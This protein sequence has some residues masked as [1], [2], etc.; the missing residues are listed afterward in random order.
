MGTALNITDEAVRQQLIKLAKEGLVEGIA[1]ANGVGR[2]V[3]IWQL[4]PAGNAR[5]PDAH[6]DLTAQLLRSIRTELGEA[7]LERLIAVR[8]QDTRRAYAQELAGA[9]DLRERVARLAAIRS[10][11]GYMAGWTEEDDG[12]LLVENHCPICVAAATCQGF[13]RAEL[14]I[15]QEV[16]G[17]E[18]NVTRIEYILSSDRRCAYR[19]TQRA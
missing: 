15:F 9:T 16:L 10:R 1:E 12:Y 19:I 11:E 8:E 4:T 18:A 13:C 7:A 5:F 2:P 17:Q 6:A 14:A 3:Q